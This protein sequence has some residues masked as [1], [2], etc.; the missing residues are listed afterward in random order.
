MLL[1]CSKD[2]YGPL[3][4]KVLWWPICS[5]CSGHC[6]LADNHPLP[7]ILL[8]L[9]LSHWPPCCSLKAPGMLQ[10]EGFVLAVLSAWKGPSL[11]FKSLLKQH[12]LMRRKLYCTAASSHIHTL[13]GLLSDFYS[14][15]HFLM[16]YIICLFIMFIS[17]P[18]TM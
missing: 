2:P 7:A 1:L 16:Y 15:Y 17:A 12:L 14:T 6:F 11:S 10:P 8:T 18:M 9:L 4:A 13:P 5:M 3:K